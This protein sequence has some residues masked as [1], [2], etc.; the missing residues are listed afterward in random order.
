MGEKDLLFMSIKLI[1]ALMYI[2]C[3]LIWKLASEA[4]PEKYHTAHSLMKKS[5]IMNLTSRL[6]CKTRINFSLFTHKGII[7]FAK[8]D[9][10][11]SDAPIGTWENPPLICLNVLDK[12]PKIGSPLV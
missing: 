10:L 7:I 3:I 1:I 4:N 2:H 9:T 12:V 6:K 8:L 11:T 5:S